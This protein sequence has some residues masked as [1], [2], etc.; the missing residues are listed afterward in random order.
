MPDISD[1]R[2]AALR[3]ALTYD[4]QT[5]FFHWKCRVRLGGTR[6]DPA[7]EIQNNGYRY[8]RH[9][10]DGVKSTY[11]AHRLA[12]WFT[13]GKWPDGDLDHID[14]NRDNNRWFNLRL[15]TRSQNNMNRHFLGSRNKS[16]HLGVGWMPNRKKWR[17]R[18]TVDARIIHLGHFANKD[19][20]IAAR[21]AAE[22]RYF[23]EYSGLQLH[24]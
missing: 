14:G 1:K 10:F 12:W 3:E 22:V 21:R 23:G 5:G 24:R 19:D 9:M 4:P 7:G 6:N 20:A 8:I 11:T 18:I 15:V 17:V 13:T 16:G 2:L